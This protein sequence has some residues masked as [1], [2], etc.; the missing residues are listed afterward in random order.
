MIDFDYIQPKTL[1]EASS[2]LRKAD[3]K[4]IP[5]SGGTD[6]LSLLKEDIISPEQVVNLKNIP[7]LTGISYE[8]GKGLKIGG[9]VTI[10]DIAE[11]PIIKEKYSVLS[12][13][14]DK[15]ASPQLRNVGTIGGNLN[16]RPRC[17]YFRKDFDCIRKGGSICYAVDGENKYHCVTGGGPCYI[18]HPSDMA[19]ALLALDASVNIF[20]GKKTRTIP[21]SDFFI[22][23][24]VNHLKE[25][26]LEP[27][28]IL[29]EIIVPE[30]PNNTKSGYYKFMEREVWD[31]AVV[32]VAAVLTKNGNSLS[33]GRI[34]FGGIAPIPWLDKNI[35]NMLKG[36]P[37][38]DESIDKAVS[39]ILAG[40]EPLEQ[41]EYK[42][43]LAKNITRNIIHKLAE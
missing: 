42:I 31:F 9:L 13:A 38:N 7:N 34:A 20:S 30:L 23:P 12:E 8:E 40:A 43:P 35:N 28:E 26:I 18:V 10:T 37:L 4:A 29:T 14:A 11:N 16:Q 2:L 36:L 25:N 15:I 41:N 22:L 1:E 5:Y 27:G 3:G 39:Q 24:E 6:A 33:K 32:S 19:V 17:W 21:V